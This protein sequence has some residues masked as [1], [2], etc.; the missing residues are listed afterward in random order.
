MPNRLLLALA[1]QEG[2]AR[3]SMGNP[4]LRP[5]VLRFVAGERLEDA[6][7]AV[8]GLNA[9]GIAA[10]LDHLGENTADRASAASAAA[11]YRDALAAIVA[12][13][14]DANI[15]VKLTAMGLDIADSVAEEN[16]SAVLQTAREHGVFV[17]VDMEGSAYTAR[18]LE[19][20]EHV[21]A[22]GYENVG[23]VIQAYLYRSAA[24]I[25]RLIAQG[26]RVRLCKG[27]YN[28]APNISF[29]RKRDTDRNYVFLLE[30][31]LEHGTYPAIATHDETII[32]HAREFARQRGISPERY[33]FQMLYGVRRD[34]Q[35]WLMKEGHNVR[36]YVPYGAQWYPYLVRRLAERP[37]NL[38][39]VL[40][41]MARDGHTPAR[42]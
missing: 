20:L 1:N 38:A 37:A 8:R 10:S 30:R 7:E 9:R 4:A 25:E 15:S 22:A 12:H 31:L 14:L 19:V 28:E 24:D 11:A 40:G 17:R 29:R 42:V 36:V 39:F 2:L 33:E 34:L 13:Q 32:T 35:E 5:M 16:L 3:F 27:A 23:P 41:N 6:V 18:T 26:V 21:R